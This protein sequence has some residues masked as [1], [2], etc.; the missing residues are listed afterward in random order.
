LSASGGTTD[1]NRIRQSAEFQELLDRLWSKWEGKKITRNPRN[2]KTSR[3]SFA[4]FL[5]GVIAA[6]CRAG[7]QDP[8]KNVDWEHVLDPDL[9]QAKNLSLLEQRYGIR[10]EEVSGR[11]RRGP[12]PPGGTV[13]TLD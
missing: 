7:I 12:T 8:L 5:A 13:T 4:E 11:R 9:S 10:A 2:W 1:I 6:A 3:R